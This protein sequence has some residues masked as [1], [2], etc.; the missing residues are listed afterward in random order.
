MKISKWLSILLVLALLLCLLPAAALADPEG[1]GQ[2]DPAEPAPA[3]T[4]GDG[5][6]P[7]QPEEP[8]EP[9]QPAEP[10]PSAQPTP[11]PQPT[12]PSQ[13]AQPAQ[14]AAEEKAEA[15][16]EEPEGP[17]VIPADGIGY[18]M[19]GET[20]YNNGGTVYNNGA[21]V[22][23][24]GGL[25]YQNGGTV[26][27]NGGVVYANGGTVYNNGGAVYRNSALVFSFDDDV[28]DSHIYGFYALSLDEDYSE[29]ADFEGLTEG[30]YLTEGQDCRIIPRE[31]LE[32]LSAEADAGVLTENEDGSWTLS[33]VD[34]DLCL[35]LEIRTLPPV[36][37]LEEGTFAEEQSL[38]I[39]GPEGAEIYYS[40]DGGDPLEEGQL[41]EEPIALTEGVQVT[42]LARIPGARPS[43]TVSGD[44]AFVHIT[45]P[46]LPD[47]TEGEDP[48]RA[49]AFL[50]ENPGQI[51][52][53]IES[54]TLEGKDAESFT[55]NTEK[56]G[57]VKAGKSDEK[58][59][60]V[61]PVKDLK[62]GSYSAVAV[63][64]LEGGQPLE[65]EIRYTVK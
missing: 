17:T 8:A 48:P 3:E 49:A 63:F 13:P 1:A 55:L 45:A 29:L 30:L 54:V 47:G 31:G 41:Y 62:K 20:V 10:E 34:A 16:E 6:E 11:A 57:K 23:N 52:A 5:E 21:L 27:N 58:T 9:E 33:E 65:L 14:P 26:Y 51:D 12:Q 35:R 59:W 38:T 15:D 22:Y 53:R 25:V 4:G 36:L 7:E 46:E 37:E 2:E 50:L 42:A 28:I 18:P 43:E 61:R 24:N 40:L 32:I 56:G 64:T 44:Y 60:T 19:E 39:S